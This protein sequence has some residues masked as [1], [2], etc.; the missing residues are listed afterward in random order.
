MAPERLTPFDSHLLRLEAAGHHCGL[1]GLTICEGPVPTTSRVRE[2]VERLLP[3][4]P[5]FAAVP[6]TVPLDV[7]RPLW[8]DAASFTAGA[9]IHAEKLKAQ[10]GR[11]AVAELVQRLADTPFDPSRPRWD[12][13]VVDGLPR[14]QWLLA[15]HL[16]LALIDGMRSTDLFS[17]VLAPRAT[18]PPVERF[19]PPSSPPRVLLDALRDLLTSPYEQVRLLR[20][21]LR[22]VRPEPAPVPPVSTEQRRL[23]VDLA[24]LK[25][26]REAHGGSVNDVLAAMTAV[27]RAAV[28]GRNEVDVTVPFAVRSLSQPGQ[29]DNQVEAVDVPL[30]TITADAVEQYREVARRLDRAARDNL[31]IGGKL[32]VRVAA[33]TTYVLAALGARACMS[34]RAD[35]VLVNAPG[36]RAAGNVFEGRSVE[37]HAAVPHPAQVG[38]CVTALSHAGKVSLALSA[39]DG[40]DTSKA[41]M[42]ST[43]AALLAASR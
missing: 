28:S 23:V 31:A 16:H 43:L 25:A 30:P 8:A 24:D 35:A 29:Y 34:S 36:P 20:S 11:D 41:A 3:S 1:V 17:C 27:G 33:P 9:H 22:R 38:L 21:T 4:V 6:Q 2:R 15:A 12:F 42:Q 13:Y 40:V 37:A 10:R 32:L 14:K 26:V 18:P 19:D 7:E 5:R 39:A